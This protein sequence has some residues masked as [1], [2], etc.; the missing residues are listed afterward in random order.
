MLKLVDPYFPPIER[1]C[2]DKCGRCNVT[3]IC[4]KIS[5][6]QSECDL[7]PVMEAL[8]DISNQN[9][10]II[11]QN[12]IIIKKIDKCCKDHDSEDV[13]YVRHSKSVSKSDED[14]NSPF[15]TY[16]TEYNVGS[17]LNSNRTIIFVGKTNSPLPVDI[18]G[19]DNVSFPVFNNDNTPLIAKNVVV[20]IETSSYIYNNKVNINV[21]TT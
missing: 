19:V 14:Q 17:I 3:E 18:V 6:L 4:T 15:I 8:S 16:K 13:I 20:G 11:N 7:T 21:V 10:T 12:N 2:L 9:N 1:E 5:Q